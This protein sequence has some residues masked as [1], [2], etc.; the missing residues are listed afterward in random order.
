MSMVATFVGLDYHQDSIQ[1][2]VLDQEGEQL[3]DRSR[4]TPRRSS[5]LPRGMALNG[6]AVAK[7]SSFASAACCGRIARGAKTP[8]RGPSDVGQAAA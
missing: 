8:T 6:F 7:T 2:C 4:T 5:G 3:C 1:I